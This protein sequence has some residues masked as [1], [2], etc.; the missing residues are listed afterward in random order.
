MMS[1][2]GTKVPV[3]GGGKM[4]V[5]CVMI[6]RVHPMPCVTIVMRDVPMMSRMCMGMMAVRPRVPTMSGVAGVV[7]SAV[8][9]MPM[10]AA[11]MTP[12]ALGKRRV[13]LGGNHPKKRR[14]KA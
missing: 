8:V 9:G 3:I 10:M 14:S 7:M 4:G 11:V 1:K 13:V 6:V 5:M 2:M 12:A